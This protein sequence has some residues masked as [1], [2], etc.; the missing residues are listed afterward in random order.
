MTGFLI[1]L[2][3]I[4]GVIIY[5]LNDRTEDDKVIRSNYSWKDKI[6]ELRG[7]IEYLE[8]K[9]D[10]LI[11]N[12]K[13]DEI[14]KNKESIKSYREEITKLQGYIYNNEKYLKKKGRI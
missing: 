14:A 10:K 7:I 11:E 1:L 8:S 13:F 3:I 9:E 12:G 2:L 4:A 5:K 6:R